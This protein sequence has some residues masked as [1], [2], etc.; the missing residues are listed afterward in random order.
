M[1][2]VIQPSM[3]TTQQDMLNLQNGKL[4]VIFRPHVEE[5]SDVVAP[6]YVI[7]NI[8]NFLL[9]NHILD[10]GTS[11]NLIP[12]S[13]TKKLYLHITKSYHDSSS[14]VSKKV[15]CIG[16]IKHLIISLA[17]IPSNNM[18][19]DVIVASIPEKIGMLSRSW[20]AK[21]GGYLQLDIT[22]AT[23]PI[24]GGESMRLYREEK[25]HT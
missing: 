12:K 11:H 15:K 18:V 7:L 2:K 14:F 4:I 9:H 6:F 3:A 8:H 21:L 5:C 22:N 24:F 20:G 17:Q 13:I 23:F 1:A 10:S 19:M 25:S 16:M